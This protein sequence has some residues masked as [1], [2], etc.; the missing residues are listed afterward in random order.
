MLRPDSTPL[1]TLLPNGVLLALLFPA[2]M[3]CTS[4]SQTDTDTQD[5]PEEPMLTSTAQRLLVVRTAGWDSVAG[6]LHTFVRAES[7]WEMATEP[8]PIVVGKNG[9]GWGRGIQDF[10]SRPG[11][12]KQEGDLKSPAGV[13][14]LGE[15][16]GYADPQAATFIKAPYT[17]V[18]AVTMCIE[19]TA[20]AHY[21]RI[22]DEGAETPDWNSTDHMLRQDDLYEWGM[23]VNHNRP[24][25]VPGGGSCIFLH[26]WRQNDSGTA[27]CTAMPKV[28]M[29]ELLAWIDPQQSPLLVQLP[30]AEYAALQAEWGLPALP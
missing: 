14:S 16:F 23:F 17:H 3:A 20:S 12:V 24:G 22:L 6:T 4:P 5:K 30:A 27:G 7:G 9:L 15:A 1:L 11:P 26:V 13:F 18:T 25:P 8:I 10:T 19:D 21:N 2:L 28:R 29:R